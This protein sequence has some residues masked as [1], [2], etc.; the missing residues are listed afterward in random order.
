MKPQDI[1]VLLKKMT[2]SGQH[3]SCRKLAES[4]RMSASSVSE[5]LERCKK[6]QLVDRNKKHVNT[7]AL[8]EFL[9]HG[10]QYVLFMLVVQWPE[11]MLLIQLLRNLV[12]P[13]MWIV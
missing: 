5:G 9:I 8:Q 13:L 7:M 12:P 1:V 6:V 10:L 2:S 4:L 11:R 3:L